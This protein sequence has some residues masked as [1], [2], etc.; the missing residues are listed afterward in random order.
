MRLIHCN[1]IVRTLDL[2][3]S[4]SLGASEDLRYDVW[5]QLL[6][7]TS[8]KIFNQT[9]TSIWRALNEAI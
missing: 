1:P 5:D 2:W 9:T 4:I 3:E 8:K 7:V 6:L